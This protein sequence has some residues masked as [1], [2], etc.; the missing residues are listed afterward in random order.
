MKVAIIDY[1]A[2]NVQSVQY[3]LDALNVPSVLTSEKSAILGA[4]KVIFP[5]VG[6]AKTAMNKINDT[7]LQVVIPKL[8]QPVLGICLGMQLMCSSSEE[9]DVKGL[10]IFDTPVKQFDSKVKVPHMGWN[11][12]S[13]LKTPLFDGIE[14]SSY[15]YFVHSF[16]IESTD[17]TIAQ[18][19][20]DGAFSAAI[21]K[22]N[23]YGCQFH[24]EKSGE[25]GMKI[26]KNFI[27]LCK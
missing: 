13:K 15:A 6:Q 14:E 9:G 23:F 22:D 1:G 27:T 2:G 26:L 17:A 20:Y 18:S 12:L 10:G 5:G 11:S 7:G 4:D 24:P 19:N 3:A 8:N 16:F 21:A 25:L